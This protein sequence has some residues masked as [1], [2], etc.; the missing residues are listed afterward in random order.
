MVVVNGG[1]GS[2]S[3]EG[4][5]PVT[6]RVKADLVSV[7]FQKRAETGL[8]VVTVLKDGRQLRSEQTTAAYGVVTVAEN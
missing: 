1:S 2:R 7:S 8:L 3:V 4:T 6:Y 5:V